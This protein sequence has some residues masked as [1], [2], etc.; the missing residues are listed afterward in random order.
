MPESNK[1]R[2]FDKNLSFEVRILV[3]PAAF[4]NY[5]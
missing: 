4:M 5:R 3:E 2:G 1:R